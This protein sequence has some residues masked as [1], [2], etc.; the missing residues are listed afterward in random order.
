MIPHE[1]SAHAR[2]GLLLT[3]VRG[4]FLRALPSDPEG[5]SRAKRALRKAFELLN[6]CD[7]CYRC[8]TP[9]NS[10]LSG[11][12]CCRNAEE[13]GGRLCEEPPEAGVDERRAHADAD[14]ESAAA[15]ERMGVRN[16][17]LETSYLPFASSLLREVGP[18]WLPVWERDN[19]PS[20]SPRNLFEAFFQPPAVPPSLALLALCEGLS[21]QSLGSTIINTRMV[22]AQ[23][24]DNIGGVGGDAGMVAGATPASDARGV[25]HI[26]RLMER[27][28][29]PSSTRRTEITLPHGEEVPLLGLAVR[30]L[31][32]N[33][34]SDGGNSDVTLTEGGDR[35]GR[36]QR[37]VEV[38]HSPPIFVG[39]DAA[40]ALASALCLAP[41]RVANSLGPIA[42]PD[43][44]PAEFFPAVSRAVV[45]AV[46]A[47]LT[48]NKKAAREAATAP[49]TAA[50]ET[51]PAAIVGDVWREFTARL[52]TAGRASDLADAWL[53]AMVAESR[54][55]TLEMVEPNGPAG[56]GVT[57]GTEAASG[58]APEEAEAAVWETWAECSGGAPEAHAWMMKRL[59]ES[60]RKPLTEALLRALWPRDGRGRHLARRGQPQPSRWPPGF[61]TA[62]CRVLIG[63]PLLPD[64]R[65]PA[66]RGEDDE[67]QHAGEGKDGTGSGAG[68]ASVFPRGRQ[69]SRDGNDDC[70]GGDADE[71]AE[72]AMDT[73]VGLVERLLLQRPLPGPAAEAIADTLAWCDRRS[74]GKARTTSRFGG[75][76]GEGGDSNEG[77]GRRRR[78]L[79]GALKRVGAVWA[80]PSFLNRSPPRQQEFYTRFLLAALRS[81]ELD[82]Q[83]GGTDGD[84]E[85][86]VVLIR[87]VGSHLDVPS[88]ETRLRGMRVGEAV[89]V[90]GGQELRF[91]EL[92]GER[93][94]ERRLR[95]EQ[96]Q[97]TGGTNPREKV[98]ADG[99]ADGVVGK[100]AGQLEPAAGG[101]GG[102]GTAEGRK[103][104]GGTA[105]AGGKRPKKTRGERRKSGAKG[106]SR[107]A[108]LA[109]EKRSGRVHGLPAGWGGVGGDSEDSGLDPDMLLP[110]GGAGS[111][112]DSDD[113]EVA[114]ADGD[115][116]ENSGNEG[117]EGVTRSSRSGSAG[118]STEES[119]AEE[120]GYGD[121]L[122][123]LGGIRLG[124]A[125]G[126][127]DGDSLEAYDLWDDQDDLAKVAEPVYLDQLIEMLRSRDKPD[128]ADQHET[129]LRCAEQLVRRHPPDLAHRAQELTRDLLYLENTSDLEGFER[130]RSGALVATATAAPES[131]ALYL[132]SEV[133]G[134]G[135]TEGTKLQILDILVQ[136]ASELSGWSTPE[137]GR[138]ASPGSN[139][140]S[141][142]MQ[143]ARGTAPQGSIRRQQHQQQHVLPESAV[144]G[145]ST[146][147]RSGES[148][149][150]G[151]VAAATQQREGSNSGSSRREKGVLS[152][153]G[154][155]RRWGYRRGPR[156]QLRRNLFG[157]LAP[158][159]FYPLA[160][161]MVLRLRLSSSVN[162]S[163]RLE[164]QR[165]PEV[166]R[167]IAAAAAASGSAEPGL[168]TPTSATPP[169]P[170]PSP[171]FSAKL[172]HCLTCLVEL[173]GNCPATPALAADLLGLAWLLRGPASES[174]E[175]R[176]AILIAVA[177][178]VERSQDGAASGAVQGQQGE[179]LRWLQAC[180]RG[181]DSGTRE[182]AE[183]VLGHSSVQALTFM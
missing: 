82:G 160:Q 154:T 130:Q 98:G 156:E 116:S 155:T 105:G 88:R 147:G 113:A 178:G 3:Q 179:L 97:G 120:E 55:Q 8:R 101:R 90:L 111:G 112:S 47:M 52:L 29:G 35:E 43:F 2:V 149:D 181:S 114:L 159:F 122:L 24:S 177:T 68:A 166:G 129:A 18:T 117:S 31:A 61:S 44:S 106:Q 135:A 92:N 45:G 153:A 84:Q 30:E 173:C 22:P 172:L 121:D 27:Y 50:T 69:Q 182:L 96:Q 60:R 5:S 21:R 80:E 71:S 62:A 87:G 48:A 150:G 108:A 140:P 124:G 169:P 175:L 74:S 59:P 15:P 46:L 57:N 38:D 39:R 42:P 152:V 133:W 23:R 85:A 32:G 95:A 126:D 136:A 58:A 64:R 183:A 63:R 180:A 7:S 104:D 66:L 86:L 164:Q 176:R 40:E 89:A 131:C 13:K 161:G 125:D 93:E 53:G 134:T 70:N 11:Q 65:L 162:P 25:Q 54:R 36:R 49:T 100:E 14:H 151:V 157:R 77:S 34:V 170:P 165:P 144:A 33:V 119:L 94:D 91:D 51:A 9:P 26:C 72:A 99:S 19:T 142:L 56:N 141:A 73:S 81:G 168:Y 67:Q 12:L 10:A 16:A 163:D 20:P 128:T 115:E 127:D 167:T 102:G 78:F 17:F 83:L 145:T 158:V 118:S 37:G 76:V 28:L 143:E 41:Q 123:G 110:L 171:L 103:E 132:G 146:A 107:G 79:M 139:Y 1:E 148:P 138:T 137:G 6:C 4:E 75:A 109:G 174:R